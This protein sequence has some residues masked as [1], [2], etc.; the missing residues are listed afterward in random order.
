MGIILLYH[1]IGLKFICNSKQMKILRFE[2]VVFFPSQIILIVIDKS[3]CNLIII[4]S[5]KV[6]VIVIG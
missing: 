5:T 2:F 1:D 6:N 4:E 3:N